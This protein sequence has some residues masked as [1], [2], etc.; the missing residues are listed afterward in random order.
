MGLEDGSMEIEDA[1][2]SVRHV[3]PH[4]VKFTVKKIEEQV[5]NLVN[6]GIILEHEVEPVTKKFKDQL[7]DSVKKMGTHNDIDQI[8]KFFPKEDH[9]GFDEQKEIRKINIGPLYS[10]NG[11]NVVAPQSTGGGGGA[12]A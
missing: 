2:D 3:P 5:R 9:G 4:P 12:P 1:V 7:T 8:G 6:M 11:I 10:T